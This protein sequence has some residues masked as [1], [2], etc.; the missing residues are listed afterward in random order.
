MSDSRKD[1]KKDAKKP[2]PSLTSASAIHLVN[3]EDSPA[4]NAQK[5]AY[6]PPSPYDSYLL[7]HDPKPIENG[8]LRRHNLSEIFRLYSQAKIRDEVNPQTHL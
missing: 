5:H 6:F 7:L 4:K 3:L 8:H 1:K 2:K